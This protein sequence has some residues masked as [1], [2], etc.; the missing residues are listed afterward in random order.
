MGT[1]KIVSCTLYQWDD[2]TKSYD[3]ISEKAL[4][5]SEVEMTYRYYKFKIE[6][7]TQFSYLTSDCKCKIKAD[8]KGYEQTYNYVGTSRNGTKVK[9]ILYQYTYGDYNTI[10][11][12]NKNSLMIFLVKS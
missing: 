8:E 3:K 2:F 9:L 6:G 4:D 7:Q 10:H 12:S 1:K 5:N 11:I